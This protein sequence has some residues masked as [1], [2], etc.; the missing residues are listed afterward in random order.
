MKPSSWKKSKANKPPFHTMLMVDDI[1]IIII[2]VSDTLEDILQQI[3]DKHETMFDRIEADLKGVKQALYS[4]H[5]VP[6]ASLSVGDIEVEY[7]LAQLC[8]LADS[9][10]AHLRR[11]HE[12]KEQAT[13]ELKQAK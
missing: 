11:V 12:E 8:R 1:D 5:V 2:I 4:S 3:Q 9:T 13:K 10:E 6:T 7:E